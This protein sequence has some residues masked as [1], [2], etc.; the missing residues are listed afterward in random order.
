[1]YVYVHVC[2]CM[3][4]CICTQHDISSTYLCVFYARVCVRAGICICM[5]ICICICVRGHITEIH[6]YK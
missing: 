6:Q 3:S 5:S 2:A 1:M 4:E